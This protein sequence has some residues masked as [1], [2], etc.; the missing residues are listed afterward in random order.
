MLTKKFNAMA[1]DEELHPNSTGETYVRARPTVAGML[2]RNGYEVM[3]KTDFD[4]KHYGG[5]GVSG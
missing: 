1:N 4:M 2:Y 5:E 3:E